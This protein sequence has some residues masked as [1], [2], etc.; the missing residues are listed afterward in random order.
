MNEDL[1]GN[2]ILRPAGI[3]SQYLIRP[4]E[5][6]IEADHETPFGIPMRLPRILCSGTFTTGFYDLRVIW[7]QHGWAL[8]IDPA[9]RAH[10]REVDFIALATETNY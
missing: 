8:P 6:P 10:L 3:G 2:L 1:L 5:V 7:F 9:V 4:L